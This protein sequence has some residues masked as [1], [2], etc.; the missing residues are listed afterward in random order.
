MPSQ[1]DSR[2]ADGQ[3]NWL[4]SGAYVDTKAKIKGRKENEIHRVE[5]DRG[6]G[7]MDGRE[8]GQGPKQVK[9]QRKEREYQRL[10]TSVPPPLPL[11]F[12]HKVDRRDRV[13]I[14]KRFHHTPLQ[15]LL[16]ERHFSRLLHLQD[17]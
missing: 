2:H 16:K 13:T 15:A 3:N 10:F 8:K 9:M 6:S 17:S 1:R 14:K 7:K 5:T 4:M 11:L 12:H